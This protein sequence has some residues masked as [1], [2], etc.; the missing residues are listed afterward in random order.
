MYLRN[1]WYVGA[2]SHEVTRNPLQRWMLDEPLVFYRTEAGE[3]VALDDRCPHRFAPLSTGE[4]IGDD[5][6]CGYHGFKFNPEGNCTHM[7]GVDKAPQKVCVRA[8]PVAEKWGWAFVWMGDADKADPALIPD[9]HWLDDPEWVGQGETLHVDGNY[10]LL[11]ENLMDLTH[12]K[13]LHKTSLANDSV[14]DFPVIVEEADNKVN[15]KRTMKNIAKTSPLWTKVGGFTEAV[16]QW[17]DVTFTPPNNVVIN[18]GVYSA[19]GTTENKEIE[20]RILNALTPETKD[21]TNYFW[22][23][24]RNFKL[25]DD[26]LT[27]MA[28]EANRDAF[29]ED[30][31]IIAQQHQMMQTIPD[32]KPVIFPHDKAVVKSGQLL[33]KLI[34]AEQDSVA[35]AAE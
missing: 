17:Q 9:Y 22:A 2:W 11:F 35:I 3:A 18:M 27:K 33:D 5:I 19:E 26:G 12:A 4:V 10:R 34:A 1:M 23:I 15:M 20:F 21:T 8:Y 32:A 7:P 25:G 28:F 24:V 31:W 13:F 16:T 29:E 6:E 30:K 14:T